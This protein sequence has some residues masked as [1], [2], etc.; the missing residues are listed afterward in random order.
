MNAQAIGIKAKSALADKFVEYVTLGHHSSE[1]RLEWH[2]IMI[3]RKASA[4]NNSIVPGY[5]C[6]VTRNTL[7][8][9]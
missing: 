5:K 1:E 7:D 2:L 3:P 8:C 4:H 9:V 6:N